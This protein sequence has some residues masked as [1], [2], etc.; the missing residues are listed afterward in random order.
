MGLFWS[1]STVSSNRN[2]DGIVIHDITL[3][4]SGVP[5]LFKLLRICT[6]SSIGRALVSKTRGWEFDP[7]GVCSFSSIN[8]QIMQKEEVVSKISGAVEEA[9]GYPVEKDEKV[10]ER[11]YMDSLDMLSVIMGL[12]REFN[13]QI[14]DETVNEIASEGLSID[15]LA[16]KL[17]TMYEL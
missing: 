8:N 7:L 9:L 2:T 16:D 5:E 10:F 3:G 4:K 17:M 13:I 12:E 1:H 6:H 11:G 14:S 15:Q